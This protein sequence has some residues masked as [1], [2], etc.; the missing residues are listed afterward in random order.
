MWIDEALSSVCTSGRTCFGA[1]TVKFK[2]LGDDLV[3]LHS[4]FVG[5]E[6][7]VVAAE[8]LKDTNAVL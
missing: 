3:R 2:L 1:L 4:A 8:D 5:G 6:L 7:E